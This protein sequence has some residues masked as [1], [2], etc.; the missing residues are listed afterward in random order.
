MEYEVVVIL[1]YPSGNLPILVCPDCFYLF[2]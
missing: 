2:L 1:L